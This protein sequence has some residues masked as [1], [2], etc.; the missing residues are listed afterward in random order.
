MSVDVSP[1]LTDE[2]RIEWL[3]ELAKQS[4]TGISI[5]YVK[6]EGFRFMSR[7]R[8]DRFHSDLRKAIDEGIKLRMPPPAPPPG[9]AS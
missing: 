1:Q 2:E 5:E 3:A 7:H 4:Y 6:G 8:I 9:A